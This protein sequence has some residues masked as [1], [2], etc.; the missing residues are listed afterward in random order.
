MTEKD[1]DL[2][3]QSAT[4]DDAAGSSEGGQV[5]SHGNQP[6]SEASGSAQSAAQKDS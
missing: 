5:G 4:A 3:A 1:K 2:G 6:L